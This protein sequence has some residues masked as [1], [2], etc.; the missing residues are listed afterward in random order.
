MSALT[1][2]ANRSQTINPSMVNFKD[3]AALALG[4]TISK[5]VEFL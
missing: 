5:I 4:L 3:L 2:V 1:V